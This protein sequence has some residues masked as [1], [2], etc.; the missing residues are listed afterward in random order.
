MSFLQLVFSLDKTIEGNN[1]ILENMSILTN[2]ATS[3]FL[4]RMNVCNVC[5]VSTGTRWSFCGNQ[6]NCRTC[7]ICRM[8]ILIGECWNWV[9]SLDILELVELPG[10][11]RNV[12]NVF[13]RS[14]RT[15]GWISRRSPC[16]L[17]VEFF[18]SGMKVS[19][20]SVCNG[21]TQRALC[22]LHVE[23]DSGWRILWIRVWCMCMGTLV[24]LELKNPVGTSSCRIAVLEVSMKTVVPLLWMEHFWNK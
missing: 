11:A 9:D 14:C 17:C 16:L 20:P 6:S 12:W 3:P 23:L 10:K 18:F 13:G 2:I 5:N 8:C 22:L 1:S 7:R 4:W 21:S 24:E 19:L 15:H